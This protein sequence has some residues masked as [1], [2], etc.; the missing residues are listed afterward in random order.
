[1]S[2]IE[3]IAVSFSLISVWL[4][5]RKS[6][7]CW[8]IGIIGILA[9]LDMFIQ[10]KDWCNMVLQIIFILQSIYGWIYWKHSKNDQVY[11]MSK[12]KLTIKITGII[13]IMSYFLTRFFNGNFSLLDSITASLSIMGMILTAYKILESWWFWIIADVFY[14]ILFI[15][16]GLYLSAITYFIFLILSTSGYITWK[17]EYDKK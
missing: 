6:I 2:I 5:I 7:W 8:P 15:S 4:T 11:K 1:M 13:F 16:S 14:V 3:I 9:F 10:E 12:I 17:N